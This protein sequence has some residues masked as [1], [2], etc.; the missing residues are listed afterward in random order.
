MVHGSGEGEFFLYKKFG[1]LL[2]KP[3]TNQ[4]LVSE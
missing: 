1:I 4:G 2:R 3:L